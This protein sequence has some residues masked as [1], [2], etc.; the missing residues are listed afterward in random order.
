MVRRIAASSRLKLDLV[1]SLAC[2]NVVGWVGSVSKWVKGVKLLAAL[3]RRG[4]RGA[5]SPSEQA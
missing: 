2:P 5:L 4:G 3:A 1:G